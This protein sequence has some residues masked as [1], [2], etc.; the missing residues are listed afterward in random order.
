MIKKILVP[1]DGSRHSDKAVDMAAEMAQRFEA[2]LVVAHSLLH[3][4]VPQEVRKLSTEKIPEI[5][6]MSMGGASVDYQVP[7]AALESIAEALLKNA[8]ERA[9]AS[10]VANVDTQ[11]DDGDPAQVIVGI[12]EKQGADMI[13]MGSRGL[14][15]FKG[16]LMG[17]VSH[18]V[19]N[20][21]D[22]SVLTVK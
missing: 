21:F 7:R 1:I 2:D 18:K 3:G 17:S 20:L 13:V 5:P 22:G 14:G 6:P 4:P 9:R 16:L 19:Q 15:D 10:G 11:W 8:S 12:A